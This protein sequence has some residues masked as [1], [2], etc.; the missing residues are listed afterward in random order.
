MRFRE[1]DHKLIRMASN[2]RYISYITYFALIIKKSY[3]KRAKY[4]YY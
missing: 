3:N 4:D 1:I 2:K